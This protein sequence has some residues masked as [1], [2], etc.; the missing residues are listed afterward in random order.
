MSYVR[1]VLQ[2]GE[3]IVAMGRLHWIGYW[4]AILCFVA[5][6]IVIGWLYSRH[7]RDWV[8]WIAWLVVSARCVSFSC[9]CAPGSIAGSPSSQ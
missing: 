8:I 2:P 1:S 5:G 9:L 7:S 4:P 6:A 3:T